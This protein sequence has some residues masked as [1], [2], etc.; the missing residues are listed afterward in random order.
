MS[1]V[2]RDEAHEAIVHAYNRPNSE[3]EVAVADLADY[4][5]AA[6]AFVALLDQHTGD[7]GELPADLDGD[8]KRQ[9]TTAQTML[10]RASSGIVDTAVERID[11]LETEAD[12]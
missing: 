8:T 4:H 7:D 10:K 6:T 9:L 12:A 1:D 2:D 3:E 11:E 5:D